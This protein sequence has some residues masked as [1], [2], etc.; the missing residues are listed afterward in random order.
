MMPLLR[1]LTGALVVGFV[2]GSCA[3][4]LQ[5]QPE[6]VTDRCAALASAS[7]PHAVI[8]EATAMEA[9]DLQPIG[10]FGVPPLPS[11]AH[12]CRVNA[13]LSP[14]PGSS[15]QVEVWLPARDAWNNKFVAVGNSGY[16]GGLGAPRLAMRNPLRRGYVT[17]ATDMGHE[18]DGASGEDASWALNQ[19]AR[20]EDWGHRATH[21]TAQFAQALIERYYGAP[22]RR[23]YFQ[24]CSDGG[25]EALME[26]QRYPDDF[27]GIIAGAPA[28]AWTD[29]M[30]SFM[31]SN[32]VA[33]LNPQSAIP[34]DKLPVIQAAVLAQC[35]MLDG[36]ADGVLTDPRQCTFNPARLQCRRGDAP[37]CLTA[38]QVTALRALYAGP[39]D[40]RTN[41]Q[42]APGY[43]VGSE[44]TP[45]AWSL[46]ISGQQAQHIGFS[47][48]FF[49]NFVFNDAE[50]DPA[51]F[52]F[53]RDPA[54]AR[55]RMAQ[56]LN[57]DNPDLSRFAANGGKLILYHGWAD[58]AI[59]PL[60]TIRY[61]DAVN[62]TMGADRVATF[63][64]LY[65]APG[66]SHCLG[67]PGANTFDM[68]TAL[69]AW[70][71]QGAAPERIVAA[72]YESDYASLLDMPPGEPTLTRPLCPYPQT[73]HYSGTG[74]TTDEANFTCRAP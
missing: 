54:I 14:V 44:A 71:E 34:D 55:A 62:A 64:R 24:G 43:P 10:A 56:H 7:L 38:P 3:P 23:S 2:L 13:T 8:A 26:A 63:A 49:R 1:A 12:Y 74:A 67:G 41:V 59:T 73:A 27:D 66:L 5:A 28:N 72:R 42:L 22:A 15:I 60:N 69:D 20:I 39:H 65:M 53:S 11:A 45:N 33:H 18:G 29:L 61:Y 37:D 68:L 16:G 58:A 51:R 40:P 9:G 17:A 36:V 70:V 57:S 32:H 48:S 19:P 47:R 4:T 21:E 31:W 6:A 25:R 30:T 46:W 50:W 52:D 35:D